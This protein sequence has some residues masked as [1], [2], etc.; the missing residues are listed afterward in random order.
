[1]IRSWYWGDAFFLSLQNLVFD[2]VFEV[3]APDLVKRFQ[4]IEKAS[5]THSL[6][7]PQLAVCSSPDVL[8]RL[9]R[10]LRLVA[11]RRVADGPLCV[12]RGPRGPIRLLAL[13]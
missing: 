5:L 10:L 4:R 8:G 12:P 6:P 11:H 13:L 7:L 9:R 1:M 3:S 2:G